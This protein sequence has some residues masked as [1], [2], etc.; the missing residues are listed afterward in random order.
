MTPFDPA[1]YGPTIEPLLRPH[2]VPAL[3]VDPP[4]RAMHAQLEALETDD[5]FAPFTVRDA[6]MAAA[7]RAGLWLFFDFLD[8][9][10]GLSQDLHTAEGS[11]WHALVHRREP[12]YDNAKY[13]FRRVGT[14]P[15]YDPL[16]RQAARLA[17]AQPHP[18]A[19][20][21]ASQVAWD[22]FAFVDLCEAACNDWAPCGP[23]CLEVQLA[24]WQLLFDFCHRHA[25]GRAA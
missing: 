21:L 24:E 19:A 5:A 11:Y 23:L 10:H 2:R 25:T 18:A 17:G 4:Y 15:A 8:E 13:W 7:C 14:H 9:A 3:A 22:P 12:D 1:A 16:R 6:G 20:F